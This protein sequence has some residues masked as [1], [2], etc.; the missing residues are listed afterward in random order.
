ML[1]KGGHGSG[2]TAVDILCDAAG[3]ERFVRPRVDTRHTHGT[4]CTLRPPSPPCWRRASAL[5]EAV[6]RAKAYVWQALQAG[7]D[8]GVGHGN[9]PVDHL[10]A[11]RRSA[12]PA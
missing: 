2:E 11:I 1:L 4:G 12:P 6:G 5:R 3:I 9:G 8:L 7:R 10:F